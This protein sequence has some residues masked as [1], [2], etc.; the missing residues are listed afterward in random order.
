MYVH[1]IWMLGTWMLV[2]LLSVRFYTLDAADNELNRGAVG[3]RGWVDR[4]TAGRMAR[5]R[6]ARGEHSPDPGGR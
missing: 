4:Q 5:L 1:H 2:L 3:S 6:P